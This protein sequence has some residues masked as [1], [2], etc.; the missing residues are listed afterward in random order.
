[1][2]ANG[3]T[4]DDPSCLDPEALLAEASRRTGLT[5]FGDP[6]FLPPLR[7]LLR[8][9]DAE[10]ALHAAGRA[11]Q[12]E[13]VI[14]ILVNRL[15]TEE[16]IRCHPEILAEDIRRPF[17]LVG[18]ART[19]TTMLQRMIACD[20]RV[21][22]LR[23]WEA[24]HPAPWADAPADGVDP[25][26]VAAE[27]EVAAMVATVPEIVAA[28][29]IAAQAPDEEIMLL[30]HSFFSTNSEAYVNV[31]T[32]SAW[33]DAQDQT[34]GYAYLKRLLQ[35]VQWQKRRR[36]ETGTRWVLK[37]PHHLGFVDL[38]FTVFPD[39]QIVQTHRDPI[40]TV[41][42]FASLVHMIRR[43]GS[44]YSEPK[45]VGRQWGSRLQR[46][47]QRCMAVRQLHEPRFLDIRYDT[48]LA[49]PMA[50]VR[51]IYDF[52]GMELPPA[53]A[54]RM[55]AWAAE[56]ARDQRAAHHYTLAEFG[57]SEEGIRR[58]FAAYYRRFLQ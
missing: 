36:G 8:A 38:L 14:G 9:M 49:D 3:M 50:Q 22:A 1:M 4:P 5:N 47:M 25:R 17:A 19:G 15:R 51:R 26:I 48:L 28:H 52:V 27:Q 10:A 32:F 20:P 16:H 33:L 44:E 18:L 35:L 6:S 13:R 11:A 42:S 37:T 54:R 31:P 56:N 12:R 23:W 46:A 39:I 40:A 43:L 7:G 21:L 57:F 58:D 45:E 55:R 41:P 2:T 24:R 53:V 34:A 29:P 30:E